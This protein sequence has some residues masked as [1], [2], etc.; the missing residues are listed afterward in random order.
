MPGSAIVILAATLHAVPAIPAVGLTLV[1]SVDWF[2]G[3]ARAVGNLVGNCVASVVVGA[4]TGGL[5]LGKAR[6]TL[7]AR[8]AVEEGL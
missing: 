3:I 5:D 4:V 8:G 1:L 2:V 7:A 6:E